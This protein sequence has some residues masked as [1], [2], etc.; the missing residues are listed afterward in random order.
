ME[1]AMN[2]G[3]KGFCLLVAGMLTCAAP[4]WVTAAA[5]QPAA[6]AAAQAEAI[7]ELD[8]VVVKGGRLFDQIVKA[9]DQFFKLYNELNTND[10]FDT[11]CAFMN[12]DVDSRIEQRVCMPAFFADAKAEQIRFN[13]LCAEQT[14]RDEEGQILSRGTCY[15]PPSAELIFFG[16]REA[17]V[18]NVLKVIGSDPRLQQIYQEVESLHAERES[19]SRKY[20]DLKAQ[21]MAA[22]AAK[23][24][25]RPTVR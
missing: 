6:P 23:P 16:R 1:H 3:L 10:D 13:V 24:R 15:E 25:T 20:D 19:L 5:E 21:E 2:K 18:N 9:E 17:Y 22:R 4:T 14:A 8:E 11:N 7:E 12:L